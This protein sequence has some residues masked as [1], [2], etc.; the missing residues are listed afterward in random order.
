MFTPTC[1][2]ATSFNLSVAA[3]CSLCPLAII[4][5]CTDSGSETK[6]S[7]FGP[8]SWISLPLTLSSSFA[9]LKFLVSATA[10]DS[11]W[12]ALKIP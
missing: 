11:A 12:S 4:S 9:S 5:T 7:P 2:P 1:W 3:V 8:S 10:I 6:F